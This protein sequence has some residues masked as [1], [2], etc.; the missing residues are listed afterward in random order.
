V[1]VAS[2]LIVGGLGRRAN[3]SR[4]Q[5]QAMAEPLFEIGVECHA[6]HRGEQTPRVLILASRRIAVAEILD[7]WLA[8]DHRYFKLKSVDGDTY[9]VRHDGPR[10][11][12]ELTMFR[13]ERSDRDRD[14]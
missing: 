5:D 14:R 6:G 12:W 7:A 3:L 13:A 1:M 9:I 4:G 11:I 8:P 2:P 10:G